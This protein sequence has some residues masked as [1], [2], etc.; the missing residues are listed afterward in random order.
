MSDLYYELLSKIW[1]CKF[2]R[3]LFGTNGELTKSTPGH[4]TGRNRAVSGMAALL[5]L[6]Q[7]LPRAMPA[8]LIFGV[9]SARDDRS[10]AVD[11]LLP[12]KTRFCLSV[13]LSSSLS[14]F[15]VA[16]PP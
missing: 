8:T 5:R 2:F 3:K 6:L 14:A 13:L 9:A 4:E 12:E 1:R 15:V 16:V 7:P 11:R 10:V